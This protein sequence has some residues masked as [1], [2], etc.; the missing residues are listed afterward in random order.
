MARQVMH[1]GWW[2]ALMILLAVVP[3]LAADTGWWRI[4]EEVEFDDEQSFDG[5]SFHLKLKSGSRAYDW[6]I[7]LYG[8]DCPETDDRFAGR[9]AEQAEKFGVAAKA[10]RAWGKKAAR[11]ARDWMRKAKEIRLYVR[12]SGKEKTRRSGGQDQ[13]YYGMIELVDGDGESTF[14]HE[15][16][17]E[18]GLARAY[19]VKAPWP[20]KDADRHGEDDAKERFEREL[21]RLEHKAEQ[22]ELG[23]WGG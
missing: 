7:R 20:P 15:L 6:V 19:G 21:K 4:Y 13:R 17:L 22:E 3:G 8:V 23:I 9:N 14:L 16:L 5:D 10:V 11:Q 2:V 12:R 18:A 1:G